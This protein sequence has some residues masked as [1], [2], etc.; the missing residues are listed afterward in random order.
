MFDGLQVVLN[1]V[2]S[3]FTSFKGVLTCIS[4]QDLQFNIVSNAICLN[5]RT[6]SILSQ[7][8]ASLATSRSDRNVLIIK[9]VVLRTHVLE[10]RMA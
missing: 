10:K 3:E 2:M 8:K 7:I 6:K 1:V 9:G 5:Y 4:V